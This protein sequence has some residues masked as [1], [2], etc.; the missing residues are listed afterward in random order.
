[1]PDEPFRVG[2]GG[3][4][5]GGV[6]Q[7]GNAGIL[8]QDIDVHRAQVPAHASDEC[9]R[10]DSVAQA[11]AGQ[12]GDLGEGPRDDDGAPL[13]NVRYGRRVIRVFDKV[14]VGFVNENGNAF[15]DAVQK[16]FYFLLADHGT[17]RVVGIAKVN[18]GELGAV[19]TRCFDEGR[20]VLAEVRTQRQADGAGVQAG[21][22]FIDG[23]ERR[24][25]AEDFLVR[26]EE[27]G[28]GD[29]KNLS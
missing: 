18:E 23:A 4:L 2:A 24:F 17:S 26:R 6:F 1:M 8:G 20:D 3:G 11:Q 12:G 28:G 7:C 13:G 19:V 29:L 27:G 5:A 22:V 15:G 21:G 9:G 10:G 16:L 25:D 14:V